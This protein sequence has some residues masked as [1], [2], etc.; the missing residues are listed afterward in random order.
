MKVDDQLILWC[1][2]IFRKKLKKVINTAAGNRWSA[3]NPTEQTLSFIIASLGICL[4]CHVRTKE[5]T[6]EAI[7]FEYSRTSYKCSRPGAPDAGRSR[8]AL[9]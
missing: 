6:I 7:L 8:T 9:A 4:N 3:R 2:E 1:Q 5:I